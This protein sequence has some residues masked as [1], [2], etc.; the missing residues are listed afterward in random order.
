MNFRIGKKETSSAIIIFSITPAFSALV[1]TNSVAL[2]TGALIN[3][4]LCFFI[5]L[6]LLL[7][8]KRYF[9]RC[10]GMA[11]V[12]ACEEKIG[13]VFSWFVTLVI[14]CLVFSL[15]IFSV[16]TLSKSIFSISTGKIKAQHIRTVICVAVAICSFLGAESLTRQ[17]YLLFYIGTLLISFIFIST[18]KGLNFENLYPLFGNDIKTTLF[19]YYP[20]CLLSGIAPFLL[21]CNH[22]KEEKSLYKYVYRF[23]SVSFLVTF[24]LFFLYSLTVAK[25]LGML[26]EESL[27][28]IFA[29]ASSGRFFHRFELFLSSLYVILAIV[30]SSFSVQTVS[31]A[32]SRLCKIDDY[33]PFVLI[34][35]LILYTLSGYTIK[36]QAYL[37]VCLTLAIISIVL[38]LYI[39]FLHN[40]SRG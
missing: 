38:P 33:R 35:S 36:P 9:K 31:Y 3:C 10:S 7:T 16:S 2:G 23:V 20:F 22:I 40:K 15:A 1:G 8:F 11:I 24:V 13:K 4:A 18:Y 6:V 17:S 28:A 34:L 12:D 19:N 39:S 32:L 21:I 14:S 27:E 26:Y 29:S 5:S 37:G 25:P 30:S